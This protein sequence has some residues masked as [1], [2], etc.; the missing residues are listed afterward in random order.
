MKR[1]VVTGGTGFVGANLV[2]RLL[3]EGHEVH[4][5]VRRD[6]T[7]WR[8]REIADHVRSHEVDLTARRALRRVL[9][10]IRPDWVFHLAAYGAYSWQQD[11]RRMVRTNVLGTMNLLDASLEAGC[12]TV[13]NSGSSSEYGLKSIAPG[14]DEAL[15]PNSEYGV[16]KAAA[17]L[18]G[19][20]LAR[21]R[22]ARIFT[23]RLYSVY[24]P[25]EDPDR[26]IP[27][28]VRCGLEG[29]LPPLASPD[30][31][32]DYVYVDDVADAFLSVAERP[33]AAEPGAIYNVGT[34][35]QTSLREVVDLARK[36]LGIVK[37]PRW[38]SMPD[39]SWDTAVWVANIEKIRREVGWIPKYTLTEG[40]SAAARWLREGDPKGDRRS[41][42]RPD[43]SGP[44]GTPA[45]RRA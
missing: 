23:L 1:V 7:T 42:E 24:G 10:T 13:V 28:L 44:F 45:Q 3:R 40:F 11:R 22:R 12:E 34:G 15:E 38:R 26:L 8:I 27:R 39:R 30:T 35:V 18:Y 29:R 31:A 16:T 32:R 21:S 20:H 19:R 9:A 2:R 36:T 4:L 33:D 5:L 37:E 25:F 17:S 6:H 41:R 14:E 43:V